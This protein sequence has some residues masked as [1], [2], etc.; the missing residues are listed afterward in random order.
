MGNKIE[1]KLI[2]TAILA[3]YNSQ[4]AYT[5]AARKIVE[6]ANGIDVVVEDEKTHELIPIM[7]FG[8]RRA[9]GCSAAIDASKCAVIAGCAGTLSDI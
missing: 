2:E 4:I 9:Y 5:T 1:T 3:I 6:A 8:A 7:E